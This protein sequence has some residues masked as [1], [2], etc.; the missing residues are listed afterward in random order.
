ML[1]RDLDELRYPLKDDVK[2]TLDTLH[3]DQKS[4]E[5][6]DINKQNYTFIHAAEKQCKPVKKQKHDE[7]IYVKPYLTIL[8]KSKYTHFAQREAIRRTWVKSDEF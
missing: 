8:I 5:I 2:I 6:I 3:G 7:I 1:E 4:A